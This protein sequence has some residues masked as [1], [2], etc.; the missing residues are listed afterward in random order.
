MLDAL[1]RDHNTALRRFLRM[2]MISHTDLEDVIQDV[3]LRLAQIDDLC[4]KFADRPDTVRSYLFTMARNLVCDRSRRAKVRHVESHIPFDEEVVHI[5]QPT[6]E[7]KLK[8]RQRLD[9]IT[10]RL[11]KMKAK[12]RR[13]FVLSRFKNLSY[14]EIADDLGVSVST[15]EKYISAALSALR[16]ECST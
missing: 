15:V 14:R 16:E 7:D 13:A 10:R 11:R 9:A 2:Q 12:H 8:T 1:F 4:G 6:P 3:W 5:R